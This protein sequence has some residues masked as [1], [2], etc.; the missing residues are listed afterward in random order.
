MQT[1]A[2]LTITPVW[3]DNVL[4][5]GVGSMFLCAVLKIKKVHPSGQ[6]AN[7]PVLGTPTLIS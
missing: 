1:M 5:S 2:Q 6:A 4:G 7:S 3:R